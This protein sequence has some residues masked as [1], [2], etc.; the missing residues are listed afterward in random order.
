[1][2]VTI[3]YVLKDHT[4]TTG[5][6]A[7]AS[8]AVLTADAA[9]PPVP[10]APT[11]ERVAEAIATIERGDFGSGIKRLEDLGEAVQGRED[12]QRA[13]LT[14]YTNTD[15][16]KEAMHEALL[17][18]KSNPNL[19]LNNEKKL[20]TEVRDTALKEGLRDWTNE[21]HKAA[22]DAAFS[23]L[24]NNLPLVGFEILY[25][26]GYGTVG[27]QYPKA[28]ARAKT[29]LARVERTKM[30]PALQ[31]TMDLQAAGITCA[32]KNHFD[33]AQRDGDERTL[34]LLKQLAAAPHPIVRPGGFKR[35]YD[36]LACLNDGQLTRT[37]AALEQRLLSRK[38]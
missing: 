38:K 28:A 12:V 23:I 17:I 2:V 31:V 16:P 6:D 15:R 19:D 8:A 36:A 32:S 30:T 25:D 3:V 27:A 34:A 29:V 1:L 13:L 7:E 5:I 22:V 11:D 24:T 35:P 21:P 9:T 4:P 10:D 26:I 37:I 33:R 18:L 20:L 14:A